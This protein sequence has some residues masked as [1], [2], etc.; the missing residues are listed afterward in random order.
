[1]PV[2]DRARARLRP[3]REWPVQLRLIDRYV[4][5]L[6]LGTI[7]S[8]VGIIMSLMVLEHIPRLIDITRLT[9]QRGFIVGQTVLGLLPE[10]GG[11]GILLGLYFS[12]AL[13]IRKLEMRGELAVIEAAGIGPWRWMRM[14]ILLTVLAAGFMMANQGWLV[15]RGEQKLAVIG[16]KMAR[17]DF[18]YVL[19]AG[20]F[21][22]LGTRVTIYFDSIDG[23]DPS[24]VGVMVVD[25]ERVYNARRGELSIAATGE[26][27][28]R[29]SGGQTLDT[30][31]GAILRFEE[32]VFRTGSETAGVLDEMA[33]RPPDRSRTLDALWYSDDPADH[34]AAYARFLWVALVLLVPALAF[35]V[36]RPPMRSTSPIGLIFGLCLLVVFLKSVSLAETVDWPL[37]PASAIAL[38]AAWIA[39]VGSLVEWQR[40]SGSGALDDK[41]ALTF[42]RLRLLVRS[43]KHDTSSARGL[44]MAERLLS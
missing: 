5:G 22:Q 35:A 24:L 20:E 13:A 33:G 8:V 23:T 44:L 7:G 1:M 18:G 19:S 30:R 27:Q 12:I 26:G 21:H 34:A 40:R 15:P 3:E 9:G 32:F 14:P 2:L 36:G 29:L 37:P 43:V 42:K 28:L 17:G 6:S 41:A 11:I 4:L 16:Q 39:I 10:Y 25:D 38:L 31:G